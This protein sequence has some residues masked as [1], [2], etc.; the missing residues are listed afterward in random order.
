MIKG[1]Y[2]EAQVS[3][4]VVFKTLL[5]ENVKICVVHILACAVKDTV[6]VHRVNIE[7]D[8]Y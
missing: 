5:K 7:I 3:V 2:H 4:E 8:R 6:L 1:L